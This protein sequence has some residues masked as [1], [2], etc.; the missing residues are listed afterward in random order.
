MTWQKIASGGL[1]DA[2]DIEQYERD[3]AEGQRGLLELDLR[4]PVP[5][6]VVSEFQAKLQEHGVL[7]AQV[8]TGSPLLRVQWRKGFPFLPVILAIILGIVV[9]AILIIGWRLFKEVF[10]S[11]V[12]PVVSGSM[13]IGLVII[14]AVVLVSMARRKRYG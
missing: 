8:T 14:A 13:V 9:L 3:I 11:G 10:P 7:E 2:T 6:S 1:L 5:Q 4:A 12:S